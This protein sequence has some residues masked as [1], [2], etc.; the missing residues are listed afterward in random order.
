[1]ENFK[2][3][4]Q[5][6]RSSEPEWIFFNIIMLFLFKVHFPF[7]IDSANSKTLWPHFVIIPSARSIFA[8]YVWSVGASR[9]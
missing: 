1:M 9:E 4:T 5:I 6:L 2:E 8:N 3:L 7:S